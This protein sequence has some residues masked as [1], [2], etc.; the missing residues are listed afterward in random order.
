MRGT[1]EAFARLPSAIR[2][3]HQ[4]VIVCKLGPQ[5]TGELRVYARRLGIDDADLVF[6][7]FVPDRELAALYRSC[8]LFVF[9]S[10]YEGFG[11]PILEAMSCGAP[12]AAAGNSSIPE[13]LGDLRGTFNAADPNDIAATLQRILE[14]PEELQLLRER[15]R[16][17]VTHFTWERV[18]R[19]V[20]KGYERALEVPSGRWRDRPRKRV[21]VAGPWPPAASRAASSSERLVTALA[22]HTDV[23]VLALPTAKAFDRAPRPGVRVWGI[24]ELDWLLELRSHDGYVYVLSGDPPN[25]PVMDA[26]VERPGVVL[27]HEESPRELQQHATAIIRPADLIAMEDSRALAERVIELL[28][29][30]QMSDSS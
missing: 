28:E 14:D 20:V 17:R 26:L 5:V 8:A 24:D 27:L 22:E 23:D 25:G 9:P 2:R 7:G 18:A 10:L 30:D 19:K 13:V 4:L 1:V 12:V 16:R 3:S 6:V 29:L 11:L 15:S 21:A